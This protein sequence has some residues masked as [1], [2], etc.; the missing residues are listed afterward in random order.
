MIAEN[1]SIRDGLL[2]NAGDF[3]DG[4]AGC[5]IDER[6][7]RLLAEQ[8]DQHGILV[9]ALGNPAGFVEQARTIESG[10]DDGGIAQAKLGDNVFA[11]VIGGG[12]GECD[13]RR[14]AQL[15]P[16]FAEARIFR[17]EIM[18][19]LADAMGFIDGQKSWTQLFEQRLKIRREQSL[20]GDIEQALKPIVQFGHHLPLHSRRKRTVEKRGG[21]VLIAELLD[22]IFHEGN[23]RRDDH[24]QPAAHDGRKLETKAFPRAGGHDAEDIAA[25]Q[26]V[27]DDLVLGRTKIVE[28]EMLL[29]LLAEVG[30]WGGIIA[31]WGKPE[32][33]IERIRRLIVDFRFPHSFPRRVAGPLVEPAE[34]FA[35][36]GSRGV[37][38]GV[39]ENRGGDLAFHAGGDAAEEWNGGGA[40]AEVFDVRAAVA[41][42]HGGELIQ[43]DV[44][45]Q[46]AMAQVNLKHF[47]PGR[48]YRGAGYRPFHRI[49]R[50]AERRGRVARGRWWRP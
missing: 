42:E 22:L 39:V 34:H 30:H 50:D 31:R 12:G 2:Q 1:G 36:D 13:G 23:Q 29:K 41:V 11:H 8:L 19:P 10:D 3:V 27:L 40:V 26:D 46:R 49:G 33:S 48:R 6:A 28:A 37:V 38:D 4:L 17:P 15:F 44:G 9:S 7:A 47:P 32:I 25:G 35:G 45:G 18:A 16:R 43:N 21:N 24:G 20:G 14:F 5:A